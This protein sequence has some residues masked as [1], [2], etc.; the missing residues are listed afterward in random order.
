MCSVAV[1]F[2]KHG[3]CVSK[4]NFMFLNKIAEENPDFLERGFKEKK[5]QGVLGHLYRDAKS[6]DALKEFM[7]NEWKNSIK[8]DYVIDENIINLT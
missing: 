4:K 5:S 8:L 3:E 2:A 7:N 1:D 6:D